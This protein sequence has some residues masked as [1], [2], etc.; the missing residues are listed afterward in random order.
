M[1]TAGVVAFEG[2]VLPVSPL[3]RYAIAVLAGAIGA[4]ALAPINWFIAMTAPMTMAVLLLDSA[5]SAKAAAWSGWW[6]G[7]GYFLA[8]LWWLGTAFFIEP[9]FVWAAPFGIFGLPAL[10]AGFFAA[11]FWLAFHLW[12]PGVIRLVVLAVALGGAE[13]LRGVVFTGFP[14]NSIGMAL[15]DTLV[16]AQSASFIGMNGLTF[17]AVALFA[18]PALAVDRAGSPVRRGALLVF[19]AGLGVLYGYGSWRL[20]AP[21]SPPVAGV[22]LRLMQPDMPLDDRFS[23]AH[24]G[25]I[26]NHY[27]E[28]ST[29]GSYPSLSGI[30][31]VTHLVWPE[32]SFPFLLDAEPRARSEIA[33]ILDKGRLLIAGAVRAEDPPEEDNRRYFNAI[34]TLDAKGHI[35]E[36][37]DKAHL[38]P[39]GEYLPFNGLLS[40]IGLRQFVHAPGGFTAATTRHLMHIP[41]LPA[42]VPLICYEAI[43]PSEL[44]PD[45][46]ERP[47]FLLNVTNDAWFG[48]TPGPSQHFAQARLRAIEQ[49][50]PL[51]RAANNGISAIL[52]GYGR[53]IALLPLGETG[54]IDGVLPQALAPT[55]YASWP[56][57]PIA[58]LF[59]L[60][61][62][63][64]LYLTKRQLTLTSESRIYT[65]A[66]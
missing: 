59:T 6:L 44:I 62:I 21:Q 58:G 10:L 18:I 47:G 24:A 20:N 39:F 36:T 15:G 43:F 22:K 3:W 2:S 57:I 4:L 55:L 33:H 60:L 12:R 64:L 11:G 17:L 41:G 29:Q 54:V 16:L 53:E 42:A 5:K 23:R 56:T 51:V 32:T 13:W 48:I 31:G 40:A 28:L 25:D 7:F 63:G 27:F 66:N 52:D 65:T 49:G 1:V 61:L 9:D 19:I 35:L 38:V 45:G 30:E 14:W 26:L 50:L 8:G 37:A 34:Q 46:A